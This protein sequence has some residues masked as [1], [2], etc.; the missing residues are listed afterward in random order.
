MRPVLLQI[1]E[2]LQKVCYSICTL[3]SYIQFNVL[4]LAMGIKMIINHMYKS[5]ETQIPEKTAWKITQCLVSTKLSF[6]CPR[7]S[8]I[9]WKIMVKFFK[10]LVLGSVTSSTLPQMLLHTT[11]AKTV[12]HTTSVLYT[13]EQLSLGSYPFWYE[14]SSQTQLS[15]SNS[16]RLSFISLVLFPLATSEPCFFIWNSMTNRENLI[17]GLWDWDWELNLIR[18]VLT[19]S[20]DKNDTICK[21][22][23]TWRIKGNSFISFRLI[24]RIDNNI[25]A[26]W[27]HFA[28]KPI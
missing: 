8:T 1:L 25:F 22:I 5:L 7:E 3:I 6:S 4:F 17:R 15:Q 9:I 24:F 16:A 23:K 18:M 21:M 26:I 10:L 19:N 2:V 13:K 14:T 27:L 12:T 28:V 20:A 11:L